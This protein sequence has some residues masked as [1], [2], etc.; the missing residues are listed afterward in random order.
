MLEELDSVDDVIAIRVSHKITG[1]DLDRVRR[2]LDCAARTSPHLD[3]DHPVTVLVTGFGDAGVELL[4]AFHVA[5]PADQGAARSAIIEDAHRRLHEA[6][7]TIPV[8][9]PPGWPTGGTKPQVCVFAGATPPAVVSIEAGTPA[10]AE[11]VGLGA[12]VDYLER[13]GLA[14]IRAH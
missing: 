1:T 11:A 4:L 6:G 8:S 12:A 7:I 13:V 14:N 3:P 10:I 9:A 2:I 5:D